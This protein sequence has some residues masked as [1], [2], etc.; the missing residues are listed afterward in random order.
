MRAVGK[1]YL[2]AFPIVVIEG[3][4][5]VGKTTLA[6]QLVANTG[7]T[8]VTLDDEDQ[9]AAAREDPAASSPRAGTGSSSSTRRSW[10]R[11]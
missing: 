4:R 5:Q 7:A 8:Y 2:A 11:G 9:L 1:Q 10:P 6:R 3:A